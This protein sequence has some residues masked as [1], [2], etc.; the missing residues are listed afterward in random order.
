MTRIN[1]EFTESGSLIVNYQYSFPRTYERQNKWVSLCL[2]NAY[3]LTVNDQTDLNLSR[4]PWAVLLCTH[5]ASGAGK[6]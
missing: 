2:R 3:P 5:R 4:L 6:P 1:P